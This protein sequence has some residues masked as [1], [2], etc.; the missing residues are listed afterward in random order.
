LDREAADFGG[1]RDARGQFAGRAAG[2]AVERRVGGKAD[3]SDA[4]QVTSEEAVGF[5]LTWIGDR[6]LQAL[7]AASGS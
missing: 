3:G 4:K 6:L 1:T 5:G 7:F 2:Y